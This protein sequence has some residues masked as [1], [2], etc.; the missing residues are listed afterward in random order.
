MPAGKRT[1]DS[2][3]YKWPWSINSSDSVYVFALKNDKAVN[4]KLGTLVRAGFRGKT[5]KT[6]EGKYI[7]CV[8]ITC[9][10]PPSES[11]DVDE[12]DD[13]VQSTQMEDETFAMCLE[14]FLPRHKST[15]WQTNEVL[16]AMYN[17]EYS[18]NTK[19]EAKFLKTYIAREI[20]ETQDN[21]MDF[22][23]TN[24]QD[25]D[26]G[27]P[28]AFT[29]TGSTKVNHAASLLAPSQG[30]TPLPL[31]RTYYTLAHLLLS[32]PVCLNYDFVVVS[33][34]TPAQPQ[35]CL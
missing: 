2:S 34:T 3:Y 35:Q 31:P 12:D 25:D 13:E 5:L 6:T 16:F 8:L 9:T 28:V 14:Q 23:S 7:P 32:L 11:Q 30:A 24:T 26:A 19:R 15:K 21:S 17:E 18:K 33:I 22:T 1:G 10:P 20:T 4:Y 27:P 29:V